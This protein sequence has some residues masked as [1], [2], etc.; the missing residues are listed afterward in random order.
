MKLRPKFWA[1]ADGRS[2]KSPPSWE[3]E[4]GKEKLWDVG[5]LIALCI[6]IESSPVVIRNR[7]F[8]SPW[9]PPSLS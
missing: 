1:K 4:T 3:R 9:S 2:K 8:R 6:N 5:D 7:Y